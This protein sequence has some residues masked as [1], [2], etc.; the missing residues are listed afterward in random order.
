MDRAVG[1]ANDERRLDPGALA[2]RGW[3]IDCA[4]H[5]EQSH[6][7]RFAFA[8][9]SIVYCLVS[10]NCPLLKGAVQLLVPE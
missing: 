3:Q 5:Q 4:H 2:N 8:D 9:I 1:R 7:R 10:E 6:E